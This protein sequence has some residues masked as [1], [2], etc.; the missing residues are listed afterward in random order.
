MPQQDTQYTTPAPAPDAGTI[1]AVAKQQGGPA[2]RAVEALVE[3]GG[4]GALDFEHFDHV[5]DALYHDV[6]EDALRA[7][8]DAL[9]DHVN[10]V[11]A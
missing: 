2:L 6:D 1:Y 9:V 5:M 11:A 8:G 3:E 10:P 7:L 4:D